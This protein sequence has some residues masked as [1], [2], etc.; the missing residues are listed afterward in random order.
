M[1][2]VG[3]ARGP[4]KKLLFCSTLVRENHFWP[5]ENHFWPG[6]NHFWGKIIF[7]QGKIREKS[8]NFKIDLLCEP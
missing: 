7:G 3:D 5:G 1:T 8:G 6:E 2:A 4:C